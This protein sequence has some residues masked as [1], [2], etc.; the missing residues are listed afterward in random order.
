LQPNNQ[1]PTRTFTAPDVGGDFI[2]QLVV[3]DDEGVSSAPDT[4]VIR[5][6]RG[7]LF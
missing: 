5:V 7:L 1:A 6:E 3:T 4:V 2:F